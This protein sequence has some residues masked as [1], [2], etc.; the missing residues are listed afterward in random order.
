MR[1]PRCA[2]NDGRFEILVENCPGNR[3]E[4]PRIRANIFALVK[5]GE[6]NWLSNLTLWV[7]KSCM[8]RHIKCW[9]QIRKNSG[10]GLDFRTVTYA[11]YWKITVYWTRTHWPAMPGG[12]SCR[13][14]W[15]EEKPP[16]PRDGN[17]RP[18]FQIELS[19]STPY[20]FFVIL[21]KLS[22][23]LAHHTFRMF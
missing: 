2:K 11:K 19:F 14:K 9:V 22:Y 16:I 10:A 12:F 17:P 23:R 3:R 7:P 1:A 18:T 20:I 4:K 15:T 6:P 13:P 21:F 8:I 5:W